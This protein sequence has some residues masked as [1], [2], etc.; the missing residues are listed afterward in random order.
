MSKILIVEDETPLLQTVSYNL[1]QEGYQVIQAQDGLAGLD[2]ARAER[3]DL[4]LLDIML[5]GI[6]GVEVC[7]L[8][9]KEMDIPIIMLTAKARE[10]DKVVG[11]E[12]GADDYVT[13]P[14]GMLEL[15]ARIRAALRRARTDAK[16]DEVLRSGDI[17]MDP[18]SHTVRVAGNEVELRPK[19]FD[20]LHALISNRGRVLE[21]SQLLERV[22]GEDEYIDAGTLDVHIRRL[23]EKIEADPSSPRH[24]ITVRGIGYK[25]AG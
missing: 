1:E 17:E 23:R 5:P 4:V 3:P 14:F 25:F 7:R 6:D 21:R 10:I 18:G 13:K 2:A 15:L 19:E 11:L 8:L 24:V 9:R 20:L 16:K 12:V 22:W